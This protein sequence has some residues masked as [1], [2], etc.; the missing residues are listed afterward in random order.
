MAD[1]AHYFLAVSAR[2][3]LHKHGKHH[4]GGKHHGHHQ[5]HGKC[6]T[7]SQVLHETPSLKVRA[8]P[9]SIEPLQGRL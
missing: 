9:C 3:L 6:K 2:D 1:C 8:C 4:E 7:I 5:G